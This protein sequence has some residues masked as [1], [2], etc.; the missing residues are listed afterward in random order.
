MNSPAVAVL[1]GDP[2]RRAAVCMQVQAVGC[3]LVTEDGAL[4]G[5]V[6]DRDIAVRAVAPGLDEE[7][8]VSLV[9][10]EPVVAVE[11]DADLAEAYRT[12]R[13]SGV[14]RIA[15]V[16]EGRPVGLLAIDDLFMD[17]FQRYADLLGPVS[18]STLS[19]QQLDDGPTSPRPG[20]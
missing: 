2:I 3:V 16:A 10:S 11:A 14:R 4:L 1:P 6:T 12:F 7:A 13:R 19:D 20:R 18:W 9:M 17:I 15:V 8:P 5:I